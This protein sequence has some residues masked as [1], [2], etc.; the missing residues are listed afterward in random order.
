MDTSPIEQVWR[1]ANSTC[2]YCRVRQQ[3]DLPK[4]QVDHIIARKHGGTDDLYNLFREH[5][6]SQAKTVST[7]RQRRAAELHGLSR[8]KRRGRQV[9]CRWPR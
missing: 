2:E 8:Q 3:Y 5:H 6:A 4:F 7:P 9:A 1:R